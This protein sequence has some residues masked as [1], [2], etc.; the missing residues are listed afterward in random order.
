MELKVIFN[1]VF[2]KVR[3]DLHSPQFTGDLVDVYRVTE[4]KFIAECTNHSNDC[5]T[6]STWNVDGEIYREK[7]LHVK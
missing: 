5:N 7:E 1:S 4:F 6:C 2:R 3:F